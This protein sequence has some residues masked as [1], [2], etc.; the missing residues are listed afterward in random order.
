MTVPL[1]LA[2]AL[3]EAYAAQARGDYPATAKFALAI[4]KAEPRTDAAHHLM[5][6]VLHH[7]G[8]VDEAIKALRRASTL[9]PRN[10]LYLSNLCEMLRQI[11]QLDQAVACGR[12]AALH[13][14]GLVA[15]V[16]ELVC[17]TNPP[18]VAL[19]V[20]LPPVITVASVRSMPP[21]ERDRSKMLPLVDVTLPELGE[22]Q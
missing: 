2:Q 7:K 19:R 5:A 8:N 22:A 18:P 17:V 20:T 21:L 15:G 1:S 9:A 16:D 13:A 14:P 4:L 11:G 3:K 12:R 10:G 6:I